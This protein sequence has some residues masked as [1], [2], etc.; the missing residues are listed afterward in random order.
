MYDFS[1]ANTKKRWQNSEN[2]LYFSICFVVTTSSCATK[3]GL[4]LIMC[5]TKISTV[6]QFLGLSNNYF[7]FCAQF[8][9]NVYQTILQPFYKDFMQINQEIQRTWR[10]LL[11]WNRR[12]IETWTFLVGG[13]GQNCPTQSFIE[14][15]N[16]E[17]VQ[18]PNLQ[19]SWQLYSHYETR[20]PV[21][22]SSL[23]ILVADL[24]RAD[25]Q[26][27][28]EAQHLHRHHQGGHRVWEKITWKNCL[29]M[30]ESKTTPLWPLHNYSPISWNTEDRALVLSAFFYG[31]IAFQVLHCLFLE[32]FL[33][34]LLR[35]RAVEWPR[36]MG[37]RK[38]LA[39]GL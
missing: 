33:D 2:S 5:V 30:S 19:I 12:V 26:L 13:Q 4:D 6:S 3:C 23:G 10:V 14:N 22:A 28:H 20:K 8:V 25:L 39:I 17:R 29:Q 31:Y 37:L 38:C 1:R 32:N 9:L 18:G 35:C 27:R 34:I 7:Y 36:S 24:R 21:M 11:S 15:I 16:L